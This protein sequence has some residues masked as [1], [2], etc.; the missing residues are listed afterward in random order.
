MRTL[1][2]AVVCPLMVAAIALV[3]T[4]C[5]GTIKLTGIKPGS[6]AAAGQS[7]FESAGCTSCHMIEGQGGVGGPDLTTVGSLN[8]TATYGG[9]LPVPVPG[10]AG[11]VYSGKS[12]FVLHTECPSCATPGSVMPAFPHFTPQQYLELATF[13]SGLGVTEK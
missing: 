5:G 2:K 9:T 6:P 7:L 13:L 12:W 11:P 10:V 3:A 8:K 4:G 1:T